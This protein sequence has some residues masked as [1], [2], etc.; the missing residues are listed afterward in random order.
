MKEKYLPIGTVV[1]LTNGTKKVMI[2]GYLPIDVEAGNKMYDYTGCLFPEGVIIDSETLAFNHD[3]IKEIVFEGLDNEESQEF[4]KT[5]NNIANI[6]NQPAATSVVAEASAEEKPATEKTDPISPAPQVEEPAPATEP[7]AAAAPAPNA[8]PTTVPAAETETLGE[9]PAPA[10]PVS[11]TT[12]IEAPGQPAIAQPIPASNIPN[13]IQI[14]PMQP[15]EPAPAAQP[16]P[17]QEE[18]VPFGGN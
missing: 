6:N 9:E 16:A 14:Q 10:A 11:Q 18:I 15:V 1:L 3:Q 13:L 17:T 7:T 8:E 5:I 2:T 4:I 12:P